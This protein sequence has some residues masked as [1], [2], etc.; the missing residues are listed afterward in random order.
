MAWVSSQQHRQGPGASEEC[1]KWLLLCFIAA[2]AAAR[3]AD[4]IADLATGCL[5]W[6]G[7][8]FDFISL[9]QISMQGWMLLC[10]F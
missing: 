1:G 2:A 5:S 3:P 4:C 9:S 8:N 7:D 10:D 6:E